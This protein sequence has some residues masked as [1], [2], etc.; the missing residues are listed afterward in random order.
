MGQ[1]RRICRDHNDDGTVTVGLPLHPLQLFPARPLR[2]EVRDL[3]AHRHSRHPERLAATVVALHQHAHRVALVRDL[4]NPRRGPDPALEAVADHARAAAHVPLGHRPAARRLHRGQRIGLGDVLATDVVERPVPGL[5]HDRKR[6]EPRPRATFDAPRHPPADH[7]MMHDP[8]TQRVRDHHRSL[9]DPR[10]AHPGRAGH[11]AVTVQGEPRRVDR[12]RHLPSARP[13]GGDTGAHRPLADHDGSRPANERG[14]T[15][16]DP[17]DVGDRV[18]GAR[19]ALEGDAQVAGAGLLGGQGH[20][21]AEN[22]AEDT[23]WSR[24]GHG[25]HFRGGL[26]SRFPLESTTNE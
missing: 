4:H 10:I 25:F 26:W 16:L 11:L 20:Y 3:A 19:R 22:Q 1:N 2:H 21:C 17:G 15:D 12:I 7:R 8:H 24:R 14:V 6:R 9:H 23:E 5:A 18:E 13:H